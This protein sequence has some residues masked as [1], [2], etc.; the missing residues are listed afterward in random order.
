MLGAHNYE[1]E[2]SRFCSLLVDDVLAVEAG[3]LTSNLSFTDQLKLKAIL[4][5]HQHYDHIRDIPAIGINMLGMNSS[6]EVYSTE[7]VY[8]ALANHLMNNIVY[9][10][11]MENPQDNPAIVFKNVEVGRTESIAGYKVL[12]IEV[13]HAVPTVGYQV[14]SKEGRAFFFTSDTGPGLTECWQKVSPD[15]LIIE[16]TT[17]ND[18][19]EFARQTGHL[20]PKLL[21]KELERLRTI[22]G[23]LPKVVIVHMTPLQEETIA[24]EIADVSRHLNADIQ[25]G[26][27]GME[28]EL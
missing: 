3:A 15:L 13:T 6:I 12:P 1:S 8:I 17:T 24:R 18:K 22:N 27:E 21:Q 2:N 16:T 28:I 14:T 19:E 11:F 25:L 5:T 10:N 9:P 26:Y 20:T 7:S 23:V 4:L